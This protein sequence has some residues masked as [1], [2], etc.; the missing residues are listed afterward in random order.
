MHFSSIAILALA[1]AAT[2]EKLTFMKAPT[3]MGLLRRD[4]DAGKVC[5]DGDTCAEACGAGH[6]SCPSSDGENYCYNPA[7]GES[8]CEYPGKG[9]ACD[10]GFF[11]AHDK[12]EIT[13]CCA[14]GSTLEACAEIYSDVSGS[15]T[16][17]P[18]VEATPS[19][20]A[21]TATA[22]E[23]TAEPTAEPTESATETV[24]SGNSTATGTGGSGPVPTESPVDIPEGA[25]ASLAPFTA[26]ALLVV[27]AVAAML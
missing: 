26:A 16:S 27:G 23:S 18:P 3:M 1:A 2:A 15:L 25:G 4:D 5:G 19:A 12:K 9:S 22:D 10:P 13:F 21:T 20:E 7:A 8:C 14:E 11:C 6:E 17:D 24:G